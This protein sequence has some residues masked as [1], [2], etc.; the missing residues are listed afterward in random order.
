M[1]YRPFEVP[2]V[3]TAPPKRNWDNA[4]GDTTSQRRQHGNSGTLRTFNLTVAQLIAGFE[5]NEDCD[6]I[7]SLGGIDNGTGI[8]VGSE[9]VFI[10]FPNNAG[11]REL[12]L[13][14]NQFVTGIRGFP[15]RQFTIL[16]NP[17]IAYTGSNYYFA[18]GKDLVI[19]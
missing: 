2:A 14:I 11:R 4:Q 10:L 12:F 15:T 5:V 7:Y 3:V 8:P 17:A 13:P 18:C 6:S 16:G 19:A 9:S 1:S